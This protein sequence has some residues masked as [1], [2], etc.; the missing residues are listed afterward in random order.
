MQRRQ[1]LL[2]LGGA[3]LAGPVGARAQTASMPLVGFL[4]SS[5]QDQ[6]M[7]RLAGFRRGLTEQGFVEGQNVAIEY[8][9]ADGDPG[10]L[11]VMAADLI[12]RQVALI[13][14][15]GSTP[16]TLVAKQATG[17]IPIVFAIG[18]D[19]VKL[20]LVASMTRPGGN[21]TGISS[22]NAE[23]AAKR[24]DVLRKL[25]PQAA[26]YFT[27]INPESALT[28]PFM[29]DLQS[30]A[31]TLGLRIE[32]LRAAS[33]KDIELAF[34]ALPKQPGNAM[35]FPPDSFFYLHRAKV[36]ALALEHQVPAIFDVRDYVEAGGLV[37]YGTDFVDVTRL[38]GN[39][40]GRILK[41]EKPADLPVQQTTKFELVLNLKT[42]KALGLA[43]SDNLLS[44]AD[45]V[46]E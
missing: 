7:S 5:S 18:A 3:C 45:D 28:E 12:R 17:T 41:G 19:P 27:L 21:A 20:G 46:I 6:N 23:L 33:E 8:R 31:A 34:A 40:A 42:A 11:S 4:H 14:T 22:A 32:I 26:R 43:V 16:A 44:T 36:T 13:A 2:A 9:W 30:A 25:V 39:Y 38:A 24:L 1:F 15:P 35:V 29:Q 10:K 37:S